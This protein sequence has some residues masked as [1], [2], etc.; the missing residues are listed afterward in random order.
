MRTHSV[1]ERSVHAD[2]VS[3]FRSTNVVALTRTN[4]TE[5]ITKVT[6][7]IRNF[8]TGRCIAVEALESIT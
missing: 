7:P 5:L 1:R 3:L 6:K 4:P 8:V 2:Q